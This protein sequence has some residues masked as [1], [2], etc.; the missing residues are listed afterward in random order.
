MANARLK[1]FHRLTLVIRPTD[2]IL[3]AKRRCGLL[4][5][6]SYVDLDMALC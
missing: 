1:I 3:Q 4:S 5:V 6:R 2:A